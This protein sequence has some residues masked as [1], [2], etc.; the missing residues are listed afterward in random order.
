M[1]VTRTERVGGLARLLSADDHAGL[2]SLHHVGQAL[3][4]L[5]LADEVDFVEGLA[6]RWPYLSEDD[7]LAR[8]GRAR[9]P[10]TNPARP[11][12]RL[13]RP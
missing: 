7:E 3:G 8:A 12:P 9:R 5:D 6:R 2:K 11:A 1:F 13:L 4:R 10:Q